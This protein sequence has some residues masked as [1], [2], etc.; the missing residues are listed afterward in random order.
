[1]K[2]L[3][4]VLVLG[5]CACAS[6]Q[7]PSEYDIVTKRPKPA[8]EDARRQ[9]CAWIDTTVAR[10]KSLANYITATSTYAETA[11]AHQDAIQRNLAVLSSRSQQ[12]NCQAAGSGP[13]D[14]CFARCRQNTD[15][16]REQCF[17][18]CNK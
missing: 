9:E 16:S 5:L 17:D 7:P 2:T 4:A 8:T 12:I 10:Q 15:R 11:L 6:K 13:F 14:E 18:S 1:M 3:V